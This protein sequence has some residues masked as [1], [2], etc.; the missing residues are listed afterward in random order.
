MLT[1]LSVLTL[2]PTILLITK[3]KEEIGYMDYYFYTSIAGLAVFLAVL[4]YSKNKIHYL[5]LH[6]ILKFAIVLGVFSIVLIHLNLL[7]NR[8]F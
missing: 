3:F 5:V 4:W 2:V 7:L 8:F 6:N 1:V